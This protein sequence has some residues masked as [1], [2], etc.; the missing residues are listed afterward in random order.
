[1]GV[2]A[3]PKAA[4]DSMRTCD[5][6]ALLQ[7]SVFVTAHSSIIF[8]IHVNAHMRVTHLVKLLGETGYGTHARKQRLK[9]LLS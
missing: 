9:M 8:R 1:M 7:Q 5:R 2:I 4:R 3:A 6:W